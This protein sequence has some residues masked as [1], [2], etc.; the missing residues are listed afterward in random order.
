MEGVK[1]MIRLD[2]VGMTAKPPHN[3]VD[4]LPLCPGAQRA[5]RGDLVGAP[6]PSPGKRRHSSLRG[7]STKMLPQSF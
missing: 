4:R 5:S 1:V 7:C 2:W 6:D 3:P